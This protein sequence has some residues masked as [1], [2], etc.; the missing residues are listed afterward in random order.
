MILSKKKIKGFDRKKQNHGADQKE[1]IRYH[2][3]H[4]L[5]QNQQWKCKNN[6]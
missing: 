3:P 4:L 1:S 5:V 6:V 2:S